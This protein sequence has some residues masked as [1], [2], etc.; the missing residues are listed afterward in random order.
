V[1]ESTE[2]AVARIVAARAGLADE[3]DR[4]EAS[5][6]AAVD[7]PAKIRRS[8]GKAAAVAAGGAFLLVGGPR[9][10]FR[11]A[12]T[13]VTGRKEAPLP[14]AMLP[15]DI[16]KALKKMGTDGDKV[17][18]TLERDFARYLDVR[19]KERR[20]EGIQAALLGIV[21]PALRVVGFQ[22]G[23]RV[24]NRLLNPDPASFEEQIQ[25]IRERRAAIGGNEPPAAGP[26]SGVG[27]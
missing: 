7:I 25:R 6:R 18:G 12:R 9:R 23:R 11:K 15:K 13:T 16:E 20:G 24:A 21:R 19:V 17:R 3:I 8:P 10:V 2:S 4:L 26:G 1:G 5:G 14:T 22:V 27:L